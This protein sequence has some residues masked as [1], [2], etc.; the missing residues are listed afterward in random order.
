MEHTGGDM[1]KIFTIICLFTVLTLNNDL[2][3]INRP[4]LTNKEVEKNVNVYIKALASK[5]IV[6]LN[7]LNPEIKNSCI[8]RANN[9]LS[10]DKAN[11]IASCISEKYNQYFSNSV[12]DVIV[13]PITELNMDKWKILEIKNNKT[14]DANAWD[15]F[16]E[17]TF[18]NNSKELYCN[19][20]SADW[21]CVYLKKAILLY[22]YLYFPQ[23]RSSKF[24]KDSTYKI[25]ESTPA[26]AIDD[27]N[28]KMLA[29]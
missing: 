8:Y 26:P 23:N 1:T 6:T 27:Q 14:G 17:S 12:N 24:F 7:K 4:E 13:S 5:D 2:Y 10:S 16:V 18:K 29:R 25:I 20:Q 11:F 22:K 15:I 9:L 21:E 19:P 28:I 3:A